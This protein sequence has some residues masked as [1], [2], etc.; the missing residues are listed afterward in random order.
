MLAVTRKK[1][2]RIPTSPIPATTATQEDQRRPWRGREAGDDEPPRPDALHERGAQL[3]GE[4]DAE[5]VRAEDQAE[6]LGRLAVDRLDHERGAGDVREH[7]GDR[8]PAGERIA[9]E[10]AVGGDVP[11]RPDRARDPAPPPGG[12]RQRLLEPERHGQEHDDPDRRQQDE[13]AVPG[14]EQ[15]DEA[16]HDR[17]DD[18]GRAVDQQGQ[19]IEPGQLRALEQVA[20]DGAGDDD[21]GRAGRPLDEAQAR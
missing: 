2:G 19:R 20:H 12:R 16:A 13:R 4:H 21:A 1:P 3:P 17:G 8:E 5:R 10:R 6:D 15:Q 7:R 11:E 9:D 14:R 18:R